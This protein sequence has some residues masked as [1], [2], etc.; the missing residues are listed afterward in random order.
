[1]IAVDSNI[2]VYAHRIDSPWY[3]H[4]YQVVAE[5]A[6][7]ESPWAIPWP[8]IVEFLGVATN[9]RI[10]Q[11]PSR[12]HEALEQVRSWLESPSLV[13]LSESTGFFPTLATTLNQAGVVGARVH[14]ARI[15]ALCI[16]HGVTT[17]YTADRDFSRFARL[18]TRNPLVGGE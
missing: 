3:A 10:Y 1:M 17:L 9:P 13:L 11:P 8:C 6:E 7:G 15:A 16:H 2:L 4:A 14:D 18:H 12:L 5:L